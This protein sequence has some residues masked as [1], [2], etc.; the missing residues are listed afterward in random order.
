MKKIYMSLVLLALVLSVSS[1]D[2]DFEE[3]NTNPN[4]ATDLDPVY[5]LN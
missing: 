2:K 3:I 5:L 4:L 1:C